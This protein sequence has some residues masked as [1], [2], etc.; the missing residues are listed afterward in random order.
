MRG[1]GGALGGRAVIHLL[2]IKSSHPIA[3]SQVSS[4]DAQQQLLR[5]EQSMLSGPPARRGQCQLS[6]PVPAR[7]LPS[8]GGVGT[9]KVSW[10][11]GQEFTVMALRCWVSV[12]SPHHPELTRAQTFLPGDHNCPFQST[13]PK[14]G[15]A[16]PL[17]LTPLLGKCLS[18]LPPSALGVS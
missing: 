17:L 13:W 1:W 9:L 8:E 12:T 5:E 6:D 2:R 16:T 3:G 10:G 15:S 4:G 11:W 18:S 7:S 14:T